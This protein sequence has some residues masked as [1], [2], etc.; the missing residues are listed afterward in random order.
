MNQ[1]HA[2][3]RIDSGDLNKTGSFKFH[4][5]IQSGINLALLQSPPPIT[6]PA[7]Q[8]ASLNIS[9]LEIEYTE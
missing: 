3:G 8:M 9:F 7:L 1:E 5:D 2:A 6:F 4:F